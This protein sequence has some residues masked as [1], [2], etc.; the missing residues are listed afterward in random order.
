M[1]THG[2]IQ[3]S[4]GDCGLQM[5]NRQNG[6]VYSEVDGFSTLLKYKT[7]N[8]GCCKVSI[9]EFACCTFKHASYS[10]H[11][12]PSLLC[13]A[14]KVDARSQSQLQA[15]LPAR[16]YEVCPILSL[17]EN[18]DQRALSVQGSSMRH[19]GSRKG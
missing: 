6:G 17:D 12:T 8:A 18:L 5:I 9:Q 1:C 14:L 16:S 10:N 11:S 19:N 13:K 3:V 7:A 4:T 15:V 2:M